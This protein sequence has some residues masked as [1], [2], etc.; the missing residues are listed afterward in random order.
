MARCLVI[1]SRDQ[2][3]LLE[4]STSL[5]RDEEWLEILLDRR[6]GEPGIAMGCEPDRRSPPSPHTDLHEHRFIV[7]PRVY[8]EPS[9]S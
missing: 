5:Y 2:P 8:R 1:V 6:H 4:R 7:I 3:A 9:L